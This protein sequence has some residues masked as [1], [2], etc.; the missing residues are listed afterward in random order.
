MPSQWALRNMG[1][2]RALLLPH[3]S[4]YKYSYMRQRA[5]GRCRKAR[6]CRKHERM[7]LDFRMGLGKYEGDLRRLCFAWAKH[8]GSRQCP[9][10]RQADA[11]ARDRDRNERWHLLSTY[12][13]TVSC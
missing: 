12:V 8:L 9:M 2:H 3:H 13:T 11:L 5:R 1:T 4:H 10:I 6:G 7:L